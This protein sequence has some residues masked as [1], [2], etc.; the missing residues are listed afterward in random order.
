MQRPST[1]FSHTVVVQEPPGQNLQNEQDGLWVG[2]VPAPID[3]SGTAASLW[4]RPIR[5]RGLAYRQYG[6][7]DIHRYVQRCGWPGIGLSARTVRL[8][9]AASR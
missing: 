6:S 2:Y 5:G 7:P 8:A 9:Q 1:R 3:G 4:T